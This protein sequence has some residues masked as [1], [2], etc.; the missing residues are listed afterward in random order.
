MDKVDIKI[1]IA[2][3]Y[4]DAGA[5][6]AEQGLKEVEEAAKQ[7][8]QATAQAAPASKEGAGERTES[9]AAAATK[10]HE[11][12][13]LAL[14]EACNAAITALKGQVDAE[15]AAAA[16]AAEATEAAHAQE[17]ARRRAAAATEQEQEQAASL[18][19]AMKLE[20]MGNKALLAELKALAAARKAAAAAGDAEA[21]KKLAAQYARAKSALEQLSSQGNLNKIA[22]MGQAQAGMQFASGLGQLGQQLQSGST[23]LAGMATQAI[24]L[25]MAMKAALGPIGWLMMA[26]QGLQLAWD[27][28]QGKKSDDINRQIE[29]TRAKTEAL[30]KAWEKLKESSKSEQDAKL[31]AAAKDFERSA[32]AADARAD[33]ERQKQEEARASQEEADR[34]RLALLEQE[35]AAE[36]ARLQAARDA[37][38]LDDAAAARQMAALEE[39]MEAERRSMG[40][41]A[42]RRQAAAQQEAAAMARALADAYAQAAQSSADRFEPVMRIK[43]PDEA[44]IAETERKLAELDEDS[45]QYAEAARRKDEIVKIM[46]ECRKALAEAGLAAASGAQ[47]NMEYVRRVQEAVAA[48]GGIARQKRAEAEAAA[49]GAAAAAQQERNRIEESEAA[50][51]TQQQTALAGLQSA[52]A[53]AQSAELQEA[54]AAVQR[55]SLGAQEAWLQKTISQLNAGSQAAGKWAEQLRAV[56]LK[57]VQDALGE[58]ETRFRLTGDYARMDNRTQAQIHAADK[59]ALQQRKAALEQLKA[60]PDVDAATLK[61]INAKLK[62]TRRQSAGLERAMAASAR[63]ALQQVEGM[64]PQKLK[65]ANKMA[66]NRLDALARAYA[67]MAKMAARAAGKGDSKAAERYQKSMRKNALAQERIAGFSGQAAAH[68]RKTAANLQAIAQGT[69]KEERGLSARQRQRRQIEK[70]LGGAA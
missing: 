54:W 62:E 2:A 12:A 57:G 3:D 68:H 65:A 69:A 31:A 60:S 67:R 70:A 21:Y 50:A 1:G 4:D 51:R 36:R 37:G 53:A 23:D 28:W 34:H 38:R 13:L 59:H 7:A 24:G 44:E 18:A 26:V 55:K 25:G 5:K 9:G 48:Q 20:T 64:K 46:A 19:A 42:A 14:A 63:A 47:E 16:A 58:L 32:Q 29:E 52:A 56:R 39:R 41:A 6:Q 43:L 22:L 35:A 61:A 27:A 49:R 33:A 66:Q 40:E 8:E 45:P 17:E 15:R 11:E 30:I 10:E